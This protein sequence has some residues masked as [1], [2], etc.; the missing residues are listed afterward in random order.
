MKLLLIFENRF[1]DF[2]EYDEFNSKRTPETM[3]EIHI[4]ETSEDG[5]TTSHLYCEYCSV[6][7]AKDVSGIYPGDGEMS[8]CLNDGRHYSYIESIDFF[9]DD[10]SLEDIFKT[11]FKR[12][13][14]AEENIN[15]RYET[16]DMKKRA[17]ENVSLKNKFEVNIK[18]VMRKCA[19]EASHHK[20]NAIDISRLY[21]DL[22]A[23]ENNALGYALWI[24]SIPALI[25]FVTKRL[26][27]CLEQLRL[28]NDALS[29]NTFLFLSIPTNS[30]LYREQEFKLE[31]FLE[32]LN[33]HHL[34]NSRETMGVH[35]HATDYEDLGITTY[36]YIVRENRKNF[37]NR[38]F[39]EHG[40]EVLKLVVEDDTNIKIVLD[41]ERW[42]TISAMQSMFL[43]S[44]A[45][46]IWPQ[47]ENDELSEEMLCRVKESILR[48]FDN[49]MKYVPSFSMVDF[50][51]SE[52]N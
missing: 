20:I 21:N 7:D 18:Q 49:A 28:Y 2:N 13:Y 41:D 52:E 35:I 12:E 16:I 38:D 40:P 14:F 23:S 1:M 25:E 11:A 43:N 4:T 32:N 42:S 24:D 10:A 6:V 36:F 47:F 30:E 17:A 50:M 39:I 3:Y 33:I 46:L 19:E 34:Y 26:N 8:I 37:Y 22:T 48:C 45:I 51:F 9:Q 5:I 15:V 27:I 29:G 31:Q 44:S